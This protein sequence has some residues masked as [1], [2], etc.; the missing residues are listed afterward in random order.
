MRKGDDD[1]LARLNALKPSSVKFDT[2]Q[3]AASVDVESNKLQTREDKLADRLKALRSGSAG[4]ASRSFSKSSDP[5]SVLIAKVQDEADVKPDATQ[6]WHESG[7]VE[8]PIEELL[9]ELGPDDQWKLDPDDPKQI[10]GL[11]KEARAA[12][13][14]DEDSEPPTEGVHESNPGEQED[15]ADQASKDTD[16]SEDQRDEVEADDYVKKVLAEL[17]VAKKYGLD[18][19]HSADQP[20]TDAEAEDSDLLNLPTAPSN[21]SDT[22]SAR[23]PISDADLEARFSKLGLNLPSTPST[24]PSTS[25][26]SKSVK[27]SSK[28]NAGLPKFTDEDIDS[29]CCICNEDGEVRCLGCDG[30]IYCQVCWREGHGSGPGQERG[31]RAVQFVRKGGGGL[32]GAA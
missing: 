25:T 24:M 7:N 12:L 13:P 3:K 11:L 31:H 15:E 21:L 9:A 29:W 10:D 26:K 18:D 8:Q 1:L 17:E 4:T 5:A 32:V 27:P 19:D 16:E 28:S 22:T 2:G 20:A 30:D 14:A 6:D 23:D